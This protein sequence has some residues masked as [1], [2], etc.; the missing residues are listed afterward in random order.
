MSETDIAVP[1]APQ[2]RVIGRPF[3]P[4]QSGNPAGRKPG[5]R[6]RLAHEYL[7]AMC[8]DFI[9]HGP[10]VIEQVRREQPAV[11]LKLQADILPKDINLSVAVDPV[12]FASRFKTAMELLGNAEEPPKP[13]R[14][15]RIINA[16][17]R[18]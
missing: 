6:S 7:T 11:W 14:Q 17:R 16:D 1:A 4:G 3:Q 12:E 10:Q 9:K 2:Q 5:S 13:R 15:L 8:E 18:R